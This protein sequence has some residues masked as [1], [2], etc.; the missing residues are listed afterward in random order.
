[1][2]PIIKAL[3]AVAV[4]AIMLGSTPAGAS[5]PRAGYWAIGIE[6]R[7]SG[8]APC[9]PATPAPCTSY[10]YSWRCLSPTEFRITKIQ[11]YMAVAGREYIGLEL[12]ARLLRRNQPATGAWRSDVERFAGRNTATRR[13][14]VVRDVGGRVGTE[15]RWDLQVQFRID[16]TGA[17]PDIV[18]GG[19]E[20]ISIDCG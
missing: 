6:L 2:H 12:K 15:D 11:T 8:P 17:R 18:R 9:D 16:R 1:M 5:E 20:P 14:M 13:L 4:S 7:A 10:V 3:T 19:R